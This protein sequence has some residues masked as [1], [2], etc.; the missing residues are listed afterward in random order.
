M[1]LYRWEDDHYK[2]PEECL[3]VDISTGGCCFTS[4]YLHGEGEVLH[5]KIKLDEYVALY[6]KYFDAYL[7][8]QE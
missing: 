8:A 1:S 6:Q 4:E 2:T 3:L 5:L 7:A